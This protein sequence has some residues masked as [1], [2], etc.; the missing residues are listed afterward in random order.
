MSSAPAFAG[1]ERLRWFNSLAA[2]EAVEVLLQVC[3]SRRWAGE[4]AAARPYPTVEAVQDAADQIW[5]KLT[6]ED[7][8]EALSGHPRIGESGGSSAEWS[9]DEQSGAASSA[10]AVKLAIKE[11]NREY[12]ERFG[13]VFLI[14]AA[15][16]SGEEILAELRRRMDNDPGTEVRVAAEEHRR[17]TRLRL[18]KLLLT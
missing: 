16:R 12:E 10:A 11:G 1:S 17:I 4:V 5:V 9:A 3:H 15:G 2:A 6:P 7:W 18:E 8:L 13:H 14:A